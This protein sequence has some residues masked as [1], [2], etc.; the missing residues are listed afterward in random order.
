MNNKQTIPTSYLVIGFAVMSLVIIGILVLFYA[1]NGDEAPKTGEVKQNSYTDPGSGE[2]VDDPEGK[3]PET[4]GVNPDQP[5]YLGFVKLLDV[6]F[7]ADQLDNLKEAFLD[8]ATQQKDTEK[9]T[10]ISITTTS[11]HQS[12][13]PN[14]GSKYSFELTM[15]RKTKYRAVVAS[16][17]ISSIRLALYPDGDP[18]PIFT[19][20]KGE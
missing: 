1:V 9:I 3:S 4:Y 15:N 19:T 18:T 20:S 11:I 16:T 12:V 10:E 5:V 7:S 6:G 17:G 14:S 2:T 13:D 8:Y